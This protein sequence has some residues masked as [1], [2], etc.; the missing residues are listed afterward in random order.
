MKRKIGFIR[1]EVRLKDFKLKI[2]LDWG[3]YG[4]KV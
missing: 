3:M 2:F 4:G 1:K